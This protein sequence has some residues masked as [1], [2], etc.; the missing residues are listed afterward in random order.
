MEIAKIGKAK[1]DEEVIAVASDILGGAKS[2]KIR[3]IVVALV[4]DDRSIGTSITG[5]VDHIHMLGTLARLTHR[6]NGIVENNSV[7]VDNFNE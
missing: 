6:L 3:G 1:P 7:P 4:M 2:G 5:E